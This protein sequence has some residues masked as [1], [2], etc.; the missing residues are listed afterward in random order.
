[1]FHFIALSSVSQGWA[2]AIVVMTNSEICEKLKKKLTAVK[3]HSPVSVFEKEEYLPLCLHGFQ[4]TRQHSF[5]EAI[6]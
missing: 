3:G 5:P 1:M 6:F 4:H 2:K